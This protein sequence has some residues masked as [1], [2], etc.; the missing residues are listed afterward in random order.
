M[1]D[2]PL[3]IVYNVGTLEVLSC[4]TTMA[5]GVVEI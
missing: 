3:A 2:S 4:L 5:A 1:L